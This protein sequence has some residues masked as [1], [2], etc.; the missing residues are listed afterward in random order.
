MRERIRY[1]GRLHERPA[2]F[3]GY[4]T[5]RNHVVLTTAEFSPF[6]YQPYTGRTQKSLTHTKPCRPIP[7]LPLLFLFPTQNLTHN[8]NKILPRNINNHHGDS[9]ARL[10]RRA[11]YLDFTSPSVEP[12]PAPGGQATQREEGFKRTWSQSE[13]FCCPSPIPTR[14]SSRPRLFPFSSPRRT[15]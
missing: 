1:Q 5:I 11:A 2:L 15:P 9:Q 13:L 6:S 8:L 4:D 14:H 10:P 3:C 12:I 7:F